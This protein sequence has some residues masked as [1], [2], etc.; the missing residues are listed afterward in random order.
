MIKDYK[1]LVKVCFWGGIKPL[2]KIVTRK[3][4]GKNDNKKP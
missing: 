4:R 3:K 2:P 1:T